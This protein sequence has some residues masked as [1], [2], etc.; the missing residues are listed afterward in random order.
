MTVL[1]DR[2]QAGSAYKEGRLELLI[3][4]RV[5]SDDDLGLFEPLNE[6]DEHGQSFNVSAKFYL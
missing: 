4:R 1:N 2:S 5:L 6:V 3:N